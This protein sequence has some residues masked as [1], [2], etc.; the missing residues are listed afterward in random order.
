[1]TRV[2]ER[3]FV[4]KSFEDKKLRI[5]PPMRNS[6]NLKKPQFTGQNKL[7]NLSNVS[8]RDRLRRS[9]VG[10]GNERSGMSEMMQIKKWKRQ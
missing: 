1:M 6:L 8:E 7:I 9:F 3:S 4:D 10:G 5:L 2:N